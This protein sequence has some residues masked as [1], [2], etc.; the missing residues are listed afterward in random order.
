VS[1]LS[2]EPLYAA[3]F[4]RFGRY[5]LHRAGIFNVWQYDD[6][7]FRFRGGRMLLRGKNGA[8]KSKAMEMLLPFLLDGDSR[9]I[10][11]V[12]RDRTTLGWLMTEGREPGNH[13]GYIW[14]ELRCV[15]SDGTQLFRT[16]GCGMKASTSTGRARPWY[17]VTD[18]RVG[19]GLRI[20]DRDNTHPLSEEAFCEQLHPEDHF[21]SASAYARRVSKEL[22]GIEDDQRYRNL[23]HLLYELR[24]PSVGE[25]IEGGEHAK[26]LASA[27]PPLDDDLIADVAR[28]FDDLD[29]I[30]N[31]L[32]ETEKTERAVSEFLE[33]YRSYTRGVVR[34]RSEDVLDAAASAEQERRELRK[35]TDL[36]EESKRIFGDAS[37]A[38]EDLEA[39]KK[40]AED[41]IEILRKKPAYAQV[42][43]MDDRRARV[44]KAKKL[45]DT[46]KGAARLARES[47][48]RDAGRVTS[49]A[50]ELTKIAQKLQT[51]R[52]EIEMLAGGVGI[53]AVLFGE[54][55][56]IVTVRAR[57][58]QPSKVDVLEAQA[59]FARY[60]SHLGNVE[61]AGDA[62][63]RVVTALIEETKKLD[64]LRQKSAQLEEALEVA[65]GRLETEEGKAK[66]AHEA[67]VAADHSW[68]RQLAEWLVGETQRA[69]QTDWSAVAEYTTVDDEQPLLD[70]GD[71]K[72]ISSLIDERI[73]PARTTATARH[74]QAIADAKATEEAVLELERRY[75][76]VEQRTEKLPQPS[77]YRTA[78]RD[79]HSGKP[80]YAL[81]DFASHVNGEDAK[82]IEAA[83]EASG[84]L[85]AWVSADSLVL[86]AGTYDVV[87]LADP[88]P[89]T[90]PSLSD[91]LVVVPAPDCCVPAA[92]VERILRSI[93]FGDH[94]ERT[95]WVDGT[96]RWR[97]GVARG[98]WAKPEVTFIGQSARMAARKRELAEIGL[99]L[100]EARAKRDAANNEELAAK[101]WL[102][103]LDAARRSVP[104]SAT[105]LRAVSELAARRGVAAGARSDHQRLVGPAQEARDAALFAEREL[106][107]N[108]TSHRLPYG[109]PEL[110]LVL[111]GL[112]QFLQK[113]AAQRQA[114]EAADPVLRRHQQACDEFADA[115]KNQ[116]VAEADAGQ[117]WK[118]YE[119]EC[120]QLRVL[121][122]TFGEDVREV[123]GKLNSAEGEVADLAR[124]IPAAVAK[125]D[126]ARVNHARAAEQLQTRRS[127]VSDADRAVGVEAEV[128]VRILG[129]PGIAL[130][131]FGED[132]PPL[133]YET[134]DDVDSATK[135]K[136]IRA[137][138]TKL[139][140]A[141]RGQEVSD[142][143][144]L[145]RF[146][147]LGSGLSVGY[148]AHQDET[149]DGVKVFSLHDDTGSHPVALVGRRLAAEVHAARSRLTEKQAQV[150]ERFLHG[151]L[152]D[153]LRRQ[154][155]DADT[156]V[157]EMNKALLEVRTSHG[158]GAKLE[159]HLREDSPSGVADAIPLL[160]DGLRGAEKN[161]KLAALLGSL[162]DAARAAN[163]TDGYE[164]HLRNALD[165]R[166][167]H[168]FTIK[169]VDDA[170]P[171]RERRL[172]SRLAV[173]QGEQRVLVYLALFS[174]AAA[175]FN[176]LQRRAPHAP[177]LILLDDAFAKVDEPTHGPLLRLLVDFNLDFIITS[178]RVTGCQPGV[179][180]LEIYECLRDPRFRG[181][182]L[183]HTQWDGHRPVLVSV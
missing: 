51:A 73:D 45:A 173:S 174:A 14:L 78:T 21:T 118:E 23:C 60:D 6:V 144:I 159:W 172:G 32:H 44:E 146:E 135:V 145:K 160:R 157:S 62:R 136:R 96:G 26:V 121:E 93:G 147:A 127:K 25:S 99:L 29:K 52:R 80:L 142:G 31:N 66:I 34:R 177:R 40:S 38:A 81:V 106:A 42:Q 68:R 48:V 54:T 3:P 79:P 85:D 2:N 59:E 176:S 151:E 69:M 182:A 19:D 183:V 58:D 46:A 153:H 17:F 171:G 63:R 20:R 152:G 163:P 158:L 126:D 167:W 70:E 170:N 74:A 155:L 100:D 33:S 92:V 64:E 41:T 43:A 39:Q 161:E 140:E 111:G 133:V 4:E 71:F 113:V 83:L 91:V 95:S 8:G 77:R 119:S 5:V 165:Y 1:L 129:T 150:F 168:A 61:R 18:K 98:Q 143:V 124:R 134:Q 149:P 169:V 72:E 141:S 30:R 24:R 180:S 36:V 120:D 86:Q 181:V 13:I 102:A 104:S 97:L 138:A 49:T 156:L 117:L 112:S 11:C 84:L 123:L 107:S 166:N 110:E 139:L 55:L 89:T 164:V 116:E 35:A 88:L 57:E 56:T 162:I 82:G 76:E 175:Y 53:D 87:L 90:V 179:P 148:D 27:L 108:A 178:E 132:S 47:A 125:R 22:F 12:K 154:L 130:A 105:M 122:E 16:L 10:D 50:Q 7:E 65:R 67:A 101:D 131:A 9:A 28:N 103:M 114:V 115:A 75:E 109:R 15:E 37:R 128:L 94:P 137:W